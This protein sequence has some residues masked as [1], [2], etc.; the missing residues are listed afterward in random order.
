[1]GGCNRLDA[2]RYDWISYFIN[3]FGQSAY[4]LEV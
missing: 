1:L 2:G 3:Q 4:Q